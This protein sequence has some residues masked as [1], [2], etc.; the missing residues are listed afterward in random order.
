MPS[1]YDTLYNWARKTSTSFGELRYAISQREDSRL[2]GDG[3]VY[4]LKSWPELPTASRTANVFR[5]L[6]VMSHRPVTRQWIVAHSKLEAS[7][8]DRFLARLVREDVV[9]VIDISK[10]GPDTS[11]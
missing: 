8:V 2:D 1:V 7:E 6:S 10:Y 5:A 4:R 9:E 11:R 3:L